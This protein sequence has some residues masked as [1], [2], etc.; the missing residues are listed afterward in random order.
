MIFNGILSFW[1][2]MSPYNLWICN[3]FNCILPRPV[4]K[5]SSKRCESFYIPCPDWSWLSWVD[6]TYRLLAVCSIYHLGEV[7]VQSQRRCWK[8]WLNWVKRLL[9]CRHAAGVEQ[10]SVKQ[11]WNPGWVKPRKLYSVT[12]GSSGQRSLLGKSFLRN[13][14]ELL[15][16]YTLSVF[17]RLNR[18]LIFLWFWIIHIH[19]KLL[20]LKVF[21]PHFSLECRVLVETL[22][23]ESNWFDF[24][25]FIIW[26]VVPYPKLGLQTV[27]RW[28]HFA[29]II[30]IFKVFNEANYRLLV[31]KFVHFS[32]I[33]AWWRIALRHFSCGLFFNGTV[34]CVSFASSRSE[35][36]LWNYAPCHWV[37][38]C[39]RT[40]YLFAQIFDQYLL[41]KL[42]FLFGSIHFRQNL[43]IYSFCPQKF[44]LFI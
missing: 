44:T 38:W 20:W 35:W 13:L 43:C 34:V 39:P 33:K 37:F 17:N 31:S 19:T 9:S 25:R 29:W 40:H 14:I 36:V 12:T 6:A 42:H 18:R 22:S 11:S 3:L 2:P 1:V 21:L 41:D 15:D 28:N 10:W 7:R 24:A 23:N 8:R 4:F 26:L 5:F 27:P 32:I 30:F 16:F